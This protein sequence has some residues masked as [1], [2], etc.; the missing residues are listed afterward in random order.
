MNSMN[1][2]NLKQALKNNHRNADM[3]RH[4]KTPIHPYSNAHEAHSGERHCVCVWPLCGASAINGTRDVTKSGIFLH[5]II[6]GMPWFSTCLHFTKCFYMLRNRWHSVNIL[7]HY[8]CDHCSHT[9]AII[10]SHTPCRIL[11]MIHFF[12]K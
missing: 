7:C 10:C 1:L 8:L 5:A 2:W 9:A 3:Q 4:V 12:K 6:S 11:K